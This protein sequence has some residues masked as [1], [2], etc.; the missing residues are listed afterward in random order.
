MLA[1]LLQPQQ[2]SG[3]HAQGPLGPPPRPP[4]L[5]TGRCGQ[6]RRPH[7]NAKLSLSAV[8]FSKLLTSL[9]VTS[10]SKIIDFY[11][12][13]FSLRLDKVCRCSEP[14][15]GSLRVHLTQQCRSGVVLALWDLCQEG[16]RTSAGTLVQVRKHRVTENARHGSI[17]LRT[18]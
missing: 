18:T 2:C 3:Q 14:T 17:H 16:P 13:Q 5:R 4:S 11:N 12:I 1:R 15:L 8:T 10:T 7:S 9:E 6:K